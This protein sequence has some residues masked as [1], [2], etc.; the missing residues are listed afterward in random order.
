MAH[1][2][3]LPHGCCYMSPSRR[4]RIP[5]ASCHHPVAC[6][7]PAAS[8]HS[9]STHSL[10]HVTVVPHTRCFMSPSRR[11]LHA[12]CCMSQLFHTSVATCYRLDARFT[13]AA[14]CHRRLLHNGCGMTPSC[15]LL[16]SHSYTSPSS[17]CSP[18][19]SPL[20]RLRPSPD[21]CIAPASLSPASCGLYFSTLSTAC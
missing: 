1:V 20:C 5:A 19:S 13:P 14:S 8:C 9:C 11:L 7:T 16:R 3:V 10:L 12:R 15:R 2:T 21:T 4:Y 6:H 17:L 18:A